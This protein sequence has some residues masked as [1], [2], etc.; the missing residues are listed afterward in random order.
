MK[1]VLFTILYLAAV[2]AIFVGVT[3]AI[4]AFS[5][6]CPDG[7]FPFLGP[8]AQWHCVPEIGRDP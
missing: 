7:T 3:K 1:K 5:P 6:N 2:A 8:M 4:Y